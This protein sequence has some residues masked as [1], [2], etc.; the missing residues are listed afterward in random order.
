M[1]SLSAEGPEDVFIAIAGG[2]YFLMMVNF[3]FT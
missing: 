3:I 2:E 1:S